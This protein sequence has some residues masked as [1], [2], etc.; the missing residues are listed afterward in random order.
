M[1]VEEAKGVNIADD[2]RTTAKPIVLC[3]SLCLSNWLYWLD[4]EAN[5][6]L[7]DGVAV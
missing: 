7:D 4:Q 6:W 3:H 2:L 5:A 1:N